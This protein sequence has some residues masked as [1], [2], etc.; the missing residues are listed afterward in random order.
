MEKTIVF[1]E[2]RQLHT[3]RDAVEFLFPF[4]VVDS[5]LVGAPE[6]ASRSSLHRLRLGVSGTLYAIWGLNGL[7]LVKVL[8]EYGKRHIAQ[9][10]KDEALAENEELMLHTGNAESPC[11]F[12]PS[13]IENPTGAVVEVNVG[14][15]R[16]MQDFGIIQLAS[17]IIDAR[18]NINALFH[19]KHGIKLIITQEERDLLQFFRD[20]NSQEEFFFRV[21]GLANA[22]GGMNLDG[23]RQVTGVTDTQR[24][25]I[26]LLEEYL[27]Q[28]DIYDEQIILT[29]RAIYRLRQ[30]YPVHGDRVSGVLDAHN[31]FGLGYPVSNYS[32]AWRSLLLNYL[33]ALQKLLDKLK[34]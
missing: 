11:P 18:D 27:K 17:Q 14:E 9:K 34:G 12:D 5:E 33:D 13:R 15:T 25:T 20:A 10:L 3:T 29:L 7:D 8:F 31:Y 1:E 24:R 26:S 23:L 16:F 30:G 2:P 4:R 32:E 22:V 6:E 19:H 28:N 21:C